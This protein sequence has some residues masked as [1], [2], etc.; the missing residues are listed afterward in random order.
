MIGKISK[1]G[2]ARLTGRTGDGQVFSVGGRLQRN[3][4]LE[5]AARIGRQVPDYIVGKL[6]FARDEVN[7]MTGSI[8]W[9][10]YRSPSE[11]YTNDFIRVVEPRGAAYKAPKPGTNPIGGAGNDQTVHLAVSDDAGAPVFDST[12]T[13]NNSGKATSSGDR[14]VVLKINRTSGL[15]SGTIESAGRAKSKFSGALVQPL[16]VGQGNV[17]MGGPVGKV[18]V[19]APVNEM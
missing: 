4:Q 12:L 8:G 16:T 18:V 9:L 3:R 5:I 6:D 15:F 1:N 14:R 11:Y 2:R 13:L 10:S 19:S 7:T 17:L